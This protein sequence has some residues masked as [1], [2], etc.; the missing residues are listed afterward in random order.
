MLTVTDLPAGRHLVTANGRG[1]GTYSARQLAEGVNIA[2]ATTNAWEPGGPWDA[3]ASL[4]KLVT[5]AKDNVQTAEYLGRLYDGNARPDADRSA[6]TDQAV[7][8]LEALQRTI[9][10]PRPYRFAIAPAAS[11]TR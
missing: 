11:E 7:A 6:V 9:A 2:F 8:D 4:L 1:V 10:R 3:Q 5:E